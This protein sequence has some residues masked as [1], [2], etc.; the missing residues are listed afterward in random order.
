MILGYALRLLPRIMGYKL[1]RFNL[2]KP[3]HP[4]LFNF[5][6]TNKCNSKCTICNIWKLY[7]KYPKKEKDE[8]K[9]WEIEKIF[10]SM[11][12][13]FLLNICGGEPYLRDDLD[14]ICALA[15]KYI[16][17]TVIH[18]PTNCLSP[19]RIKKLTLSILKKI[20][21]KVHLTVKMS[22]DGVD[23]NHDKIRGIKGNFKKLLKTYD[24]LSQIRRKH[25]NLYVDAGTTVSIKNLNNLNE[26]N[27]YVEKNFNLDN[28]L[29]EIADT[30][31]ELFN[32]NVDKNLKKKFKIME[33]LSITPTGKE[34]TKVV[35][36][37][38][39]E[40]I[41]KLRTR[42]KLSKITQA[43]RLVYYKRAAKV[44]SKNKRVVPCY[45]GISNA[46]LNPWGGLWIC[47]VQAF[48]KEIGNLR[49]YNYDFDK[50]WYSNNAK[51]IRKWVK[52]KHCN[53][54]LVG[55]AFLDTV[56]NPKELIKVFW[57]Y[58]FG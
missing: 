53:C 48:K 20:P 25:P 39:D 9:L 44:M 42:R 41:K 14:D 11:K 57:Y 7:K 34:Y 50:I 27:K 16:K 43:L 6:V 56:M 33:D 24:I 52:E 38:C 51:K 40:V 47:N 29:H 31:A 28:F 46:H 1:A 12:P 30:R 37:L 10:R 15:C 26:I 3:P 32:V 54:P 19:N 58:F 2:V 45:A 8:L 17:P 18:M 21:K 22:L 55:Q 23:E 35:N 36:F 4:I 49:N 13:I 5:S